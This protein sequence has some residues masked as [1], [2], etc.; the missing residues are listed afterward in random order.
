MDNDLRSQ[1]SDLVGSTVVLVDDN[2]DLREGLRELFLDAGLKCQEYASADDAIC[3]LNEN[4]RDVSVCVVD[5]V[6]S[7]GEHSGIDLL[8]DIRQLDH[9][10][11]TLA[12]SG[13]K[14]AVSGTDVMQIGASLYVRKPFDPAVL[15]SMVA[16]LIR[17]RALAQEMAIT[18]RER[19]T[20]QELLDAMSV[21]VTLVDPEGM[22]IAANKSARTANQIDDSSI[23][24]NCCWEVVCDIES[25]CDVCPAKSQVEGPEAWDRLLSRHVVRR[26]KNLIVETSPVLDSMGRT[27]Y[28]LQTATDIT[29]Y[30]RA[31]ALTGRLNQWARELTPIGICERTASVLRE[32]FGYSR[33]R[34]YLRKNGTLHGVACRG[35][36]PGFRISKYK[37]EQDDP[38]A[39]KAFDEQKPI[40][41]PAE[42]LRQDRFYGEFA[43]EGCKYQLQVPASSAASQLC[44][45]TIDDKGVEDCLTE[46]DS[47]L[48]ALIG[49]T[50]GDAIQAAIARQERERRLEWYRSFEVVDEVNL[51][52]VDD[53]LS[54]IHI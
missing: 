20:L 18:G 52:H 24:S 29:R 39:Q 5:L 22:L 16:A 50:V 53:G 33:V 44:T 30:K 35:M 6:L 47:D 51:K 10:L 3:W 31:V 48:L 32:E 41:I 38:N 34:I 27:R 28:Y 9:S 42:Q 17:M 54:L 14:E 26:E 40:L 1:V 37:L 4:Y 2:P 8:N 7:D 15:L 19:D 25:A 36:P 45:I 13:D 23:G 46:E 49:T 12:Y 11:P 43:K 21:E